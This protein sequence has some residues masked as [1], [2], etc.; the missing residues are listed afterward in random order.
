MLGLTKD[1]SSIIAY[2]LLGGC[3]IWL[4][5]CLITNSTG[6]R[7]VQHHSQ[8]VLVHKYVI[9]RLISSKVYKKKLYYL[10]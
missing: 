2:F 1:S 3:L 5:F 10:T 4:N 9:A 6:K 8:V 7:P